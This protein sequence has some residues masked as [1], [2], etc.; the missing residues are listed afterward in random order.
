MLAAM[1]LSIIFL[2]IDI[3]SVTEGLKSVLPVG[4]NPFWK[5]SFVFK[6]LTDSVI[7]D[8]FKTALDKLSH[9]NLSRVE[10]RSGGNWASS[11]NKTVERT[12]ERRGPQMPGASKHVATVTGTRGR[13]G[14][15]ESEDP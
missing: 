15:S 8:D 11:K 1:I 12:T 6:L 3:F 4:I 7:L 5:L 13:V 14:S 2:I 10:E 9:Y